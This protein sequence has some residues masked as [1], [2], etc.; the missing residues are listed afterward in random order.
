M[1]GQFEQYAFPPLEAATPEGLLAGGGDLS[2][3]RLLA[4]YR[5]GIFPWYSAGQPI[6]W[7]SPNP[8]TVLYPGQLRIKR[9]LRSALRKEDFRITTDRA[10]ETVIE[11]CAAPRPGD[12]DTGTWITTEMMEAY[13]QLYREGHAHSVEVWQEG[14]LAGGLY[15]IAIGRVFFGESMFSRVRDASKVGLVGLVRILTEKRFVV[16]DCQL[17]SDH[18]FSLGARSIPRSR[19]ITQLGQAVDKVDTPGLWDVELN[20]LSLL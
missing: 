9:S 2:S 18:L 8:R 19:F 10:F 20:D 7:W 17:P 13:T 12:S 6:L 1:S 14:T 3:G 4:A 16:I 5:K 15:G 11:G